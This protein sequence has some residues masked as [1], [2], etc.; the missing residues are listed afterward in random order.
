MPIN[1]ATKG[2]ELIDKLNQL[3]LANSRDDGFVFAQLRRDAEALLKVDA[4][5]GYMVLGAI[6]A[7]KRDIVSLHE[8][9]RKAIK[10]NPND[11]DVHYNYGVSLSSAG[12]ISDGLKEIRKAYDMD[13]T[14]SRYL[15]LIDHIFKACR[16]I[17]ASELIS[18]FTNRDK[19]PL[20][21]LLEVAGK[22]ARAKNATDDEMEDL[23]R[24]AIR[25]LH[26]H[27]IYPERISFRAPMQEASSTIHVLIQIDETIESVVSLNVKF[28]DKL[29][30]ENYRPEIIDALSVG[31]TRGN[32]LDGH[33]T[34]GLA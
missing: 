17:E 21:P 34:P 9:H 27:E 22:V 25:I 20:A 24:T 23:Q 8:N 14:P 11:P 1:P 5:S 18:K 3:S 2:K 33:N 6:A 31:Y 28:A 10:I 29:A 13:S 12:F 4:L 30:A 26:E 32:L 15:G 7:F 19:Y 16:F